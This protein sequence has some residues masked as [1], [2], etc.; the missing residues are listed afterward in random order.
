MTAGELPILRSFR[1]SYPISA[2]LRI[3]TLQILSETG[4]RRGRQRES[5]EFA[6]MR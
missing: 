1:T 5:A 2:V 4:W 3:I 6:S